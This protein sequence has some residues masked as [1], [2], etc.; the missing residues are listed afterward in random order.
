LDKQYRVLEKIGSGAFGEIYKIE[1]VNS[2]QI[3]AVKAEGQNVDKKQMMLFW[4]SKII[5]LLKSKDMQSVFNV[6]F[7]GHE[8]SL[9]G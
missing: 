7:I 8:K 3:Y 4:E 5:K 1:N 9:E 2:K 6:H